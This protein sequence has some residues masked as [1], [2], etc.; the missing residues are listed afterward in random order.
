LALIATDSVQ[1][2]YPLIMSCYFIAQI[3]INDDKEYQKNPD[4]AG[5]RYHIQHADDV[6]YQFKNL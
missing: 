1:I 5:E 6:C 3:K 4:K 2:C